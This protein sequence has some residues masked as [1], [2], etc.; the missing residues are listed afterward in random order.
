MAGM[1]MFNIREGQ[2]KRSIRHGNAC[3]RRLASGDSTERDEL[4]KRIAD[5][6]RELTDLRKRY[7]TE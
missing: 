4:F 7:R 5:L 6:Q 1:L 2:L 3:L